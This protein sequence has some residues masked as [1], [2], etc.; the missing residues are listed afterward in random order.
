MKD[1]ENMKITK[2]ISVFALTALISLL[3]AVT[4]FGATGKITGLKQDTATKTSVSVVWDAYLGTNIKYEVQTSYDNQDFK[5]CASTYTTS[6]NISVKALKPFYVKVRAVNALN[7]KEVAE[8]DSIQVVSVPEKV[9]DLKQ[10]SATTSSITINWTAA[11]GATSYEIIRYVNSNEYV[12]GSTTATK[13][14]VKGFNNELE[15]KTAIGVRPVRTANGFSAKETGYYSIASLSANKITLVPEKIQG[16]TVTNYYNSLKQVT[17]GF[18]VPEYHNGYIYELYTYK[19]KKVSSGNITSTSYNKLKNIKNKFY[20][21]RV[22]AY[23]TINNRN[24]YG[25][26]SDYTVFAQQPKVTL[27]KSGSRLKMTWKKVSGAKNYTVY[28][29]TS[30]NSGYKK[31]ATTKKASYTAKKFK[32]KKL[33]RKK[34]YYVYVV[35][36]RKEG[37]KTY[38]SPAIKC[39]YLF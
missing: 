35:A 25:A 3:F 26:W 28:M 12:V 34:I 24:Y 32:K 31:I 36:N 27:D 17:F 8:S 22:R 5:P 2:K 23:V 33:S 14:T 9:K 16:V 18:T 37:K 21:L 39:Y 10:T 15:N 4:V 19:N 1:D 11:E 38:K 29:S 7:R 30:K 13:Y 20:K 6:Y